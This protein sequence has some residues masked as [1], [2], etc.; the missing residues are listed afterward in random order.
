MKKISFFL[1]VILTFFSSCGS[2]VTDSEKERRLTETCSFDITDTEKIGVE[3]VSKVPGDQPCSI[4]VKSFGAS[5]N[6]I[7]DD[8]EPIKTALASFSEIGGCVFF[9]SGTYKITSEITVPSNI[10]LLGDNATILV[11]FKGRYAIRAEGSYGPPVLVTSDI[12]AGD[13]VVKISDIASFTEGDLIQVMDKRNKERYAREI[14]TISKIEDGSITLTAP[15]MMPY[16]TGYSSEVNQIKG[17]R[18]LRIE[19]LTFEGTSSSDI[20]FMVFI[21]NA[22]LVVVKDCIIKNHISAS[23]PDTVISIYVAQSEDV[24][25]EN[26][27]RYGVADY[28]L[29]NGNCISVY[30]TGKTVITQNSCLGSAFGIS[31]FVGQGNMISY[32]YIEGTQRSGHRG[33]KL[34]GSY[35]I[36]VISNKIIRTDSGIKHEESGENLI[37]RNIIFDCGVA[38]WSAGINLSNHEAS[39]ENQFD[40]IILEKNY[41]KGQHGAGIFIDM[42]NSKVVVKDNIIESSGKGIQDDSAQAQIENNCIVNSPKVLFKGIRP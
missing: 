32:N 40:N 39:I 7:D 34:S 33:I 38:S 3:A 21:R 35:F 1:L 23:A 29:E 31:D 28:K 2:G 12:V 13:T 27:L 11:D 37:K 30:G 19:G 10:R 9:P 8:T 15:M 42:N 36:E 26:N 25:I 41:V 6:G 24:R 20:T 17:L 18:N 14:K 22:N 16:K 5:G 4:D